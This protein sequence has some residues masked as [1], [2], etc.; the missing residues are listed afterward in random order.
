MEKGLPAVVDLRRGGGAAPS[1]P[2]FPIK[3]L[4]YMAANRPCVMFAS[5]ASG[6]AHGEHV[7]LAGEDT[8]ESLGD[9][10]IRVLTDQS[11]GSPAGGWRKPICARAARSAQGRRAALP[12]VLRLAEADG[13]GGKSNR[14]RD[15]E[16]QS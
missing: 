2:G 7:W 11:P 8:C 1:A 6:I 16:F 13:A 12:S 15:V 9:G 14:G 5:S 10:I 4:N 3:L